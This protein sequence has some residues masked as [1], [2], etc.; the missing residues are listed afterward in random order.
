MSRSIRLTA[1]L[2]L[3]LSISA[4][5]QRGG[6][7]G[8]TGGSTTGSRP[9]TPT[10]TPTFP[11]PGTNIPNTQTQRQILYITGSVVVSQGT[12]PPEPVAIERV[13][14]GSAHK[15]GYTDS[16]GHYQIQ[17][18]QNF[19]LQD[20]S[21]SGSATSGLGGM[22]SGS[23]IMGPPSGMGGVNPR[24]LIGCELRAMLPGFQSSSVMIRVEGAFGEIRMDTIVLQPI[25]GGSGS[26]IS[27]TTMQAPGGARKAYDKAQKDISKNDLKNAEK[28]LTKAVQE[29]PK[30]A[31]AWAL[32]GMVHQDF[33]QNDQAESDYQHAI[34]ADSQ[35]A[36]PYFGLAVMAANQKNW[37]ETVRLS[38]QVNRLA[39]MAYPEAYFFSGVGSYNLG[40]MDDA[41]KSFRKFISLD[42]DHRRPA[43]ALYL[44]DILA[45]KQDFAGAAEQAKAYLAAEPNAPNSESIRAKVKELEQMS[46]S[47]PK[48]Q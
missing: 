12:P 45:R 37:K 26:T 17:L 41:E 36:K 7:G 29:Y 3:A 2:I 24:D 43:A 5:A 35:Y 19:E 44:G 15:E 16:K 23:S 4:F 30:F 1:V 32:L 33:Q 25:G 21:E 10:N 6:S 27:L 40:N 28:E 38:E 18:G 13:C 47:A 31:A 46:A 14:G 11:Q 48:Q 42:R 39:P 34:A 9:S 20:V 8:N 22:N